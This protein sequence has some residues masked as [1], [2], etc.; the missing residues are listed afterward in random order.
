M[1]LLEVQPEIVRLLADA[2]ASPL[3][4]CLQLQC[5]FDSTAVRRLI[6]GR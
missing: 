3:M 5:D 1:Q 6:K 4:R 2:F